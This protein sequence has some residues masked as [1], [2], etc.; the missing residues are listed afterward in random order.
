[1]GTTEGSVSERIEQIK[2][3]RVGYINPK[4][5][6]VEPF[7]DGGRDA[8]ALEPVENI[9]SASVKAVVER[10]VRARFGTPAQKVLDDDSIIGAVK[11][12]GDR[13]DPDKATIR[14]VRTMVE[15]SVN[16]RK[17]FKRETPD[18]LCV[19]MVS[20]ARSTKDEIRRLLKSYCPEIRSARAHRSR[21]TC[22]LAIYNAR[23]N[24]VYRLRVDAIPED[25]IDEIERECD[26]LL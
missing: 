11:S 2:Q 14:N 22:Y 6:E 4:T 19:F 1:M 7:N 13:I 3:P 9:S 21:N 20:E 15:R 18:S 8:G 16:F 17:N 26:P 10:M 5:L 25:V 23:L 12:F 24:E